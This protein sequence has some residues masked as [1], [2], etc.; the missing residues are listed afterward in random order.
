MSRPDPDADLATLVRDAAP[1]PSPEFVD[2]LDTRVAER[3]GAPARPRRAWRLPRRRLAGGLA[4]ACLLAA[5]AVVAIATR[6]TGSSVESLNMSRTRPDASAS[7]AGR[8]GAAAPA[9]QA[10]PSPG[11][12]VPSAPARRVIR[13]TQLALTAVLKDF[14][15]T[16]DGVI[17]TADRFGGI[18]QRSNVDQTGSTGH[19]SFDL[20]VPASRLD[21]AMAALSRLAHVRSRSAA[22]QDVTANYLSAKERVDAARAERRGILRSLAKGDDPVLR[23]RLREV[24]ARL[25]RARGDLRSLKRRTDYVRVAVT[26]DAARRGEAIPGTTH[27]GSWTPRDA[28]HDAGRIL[29]VAAG[30]ALIALAVGLPLALL[31]GLAALGGR[32]ARRRRREAALG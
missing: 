1:R 27:D 17:A 22:S 5:I 3:F 4:A 24:D 15:S 7:E 25:A 26:V 14:A 28:L 30:I 2:R 21:E 31:G 8:T 13:D 10:A 18:V 16:T 32:A 12:V 19:A 23:L 9:R 20:R 29:Q 6:D 11:A